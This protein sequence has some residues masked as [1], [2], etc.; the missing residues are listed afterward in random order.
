MKDSGIDW[1]G[2]MPDSWSI[3]KISQYFKHHKQKNIG[4]QETNLLSLSYGKIKRRDI[5][6]G[7]GLLPE[8]FEGYNIVDIDD[9]VLRMT[10]LQNDHNSLRQGI[11]NEKGILTSAYIT[12]RK[13]NEVDSKFVYY[14]LFAFDIVKGYYGMGSGVR[15][16]VTYSDICKLPLVLPKL[17]EQNA[18][19]SLIDEKISTIDSIIGETKESIEELKKYK[20]SIITEAVTRGLNPNAPLKDSHIDWIGQIPEKWSINSISQYFTQVKDKNKNLVETNLLSLSYG[21]LKRKNINGGDGLL[22]ESFEGYNIINYK[23]IVLRMTD[24]QNDHT[25][26]RQGFVEEKGII[27]SAYI[28]MRPQLKINSKFVYYQLYAFDINKGYYGMG[29]GVRQGV[30]Y[31]DIKQ[32]KLALPQ[33]E[34]QNEIADSLDKLSADIESLISEKSELVVEYENYKKS[35]IFEYVTG[36]KEV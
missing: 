2:T 7:D 35:I 28:T 23:D 20:Q 36:K 14:Q 6:S 30:T 17:I 32:L 15:Q 26:L 19:V 4:M 33:I 25:S 10:D 5:N 8:S 21:K 18:I 12:I 22:P 3:N 27:T 34:E 9:V 29:S 31:N 16:G 1:F 24:L 11:V 13:R